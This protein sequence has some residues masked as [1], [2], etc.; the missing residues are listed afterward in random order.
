MVTNIKMTLL[1][2]PFRFVLNLA[3]LQTVT[4]GLMT[5]VWLPA[6]PIVET[7]PTLFQKIPPNEEAWSAIHGNILDDYFFKNYILQNP[8]HLPQS[9]E[10]PL[11]YSLQGAPWLTETKQSA[12]LIPDLDIP[13][14]DGLIYPN[15]AFAGVQ[16]GIPSELSIQA[17]ITKDSGNFAG[18][19]ETAIAKT[20]SAGGGVIQIEAGSFALKR[21]VV[22]TSNRV[23]IRGRGMGENGTVFRLDYGFKGK[24]IL[25]LGLVPDKANIAAV[26]PH[27]EIG[28]QAAVQRGGGWEETPPP[29]GEISIE[30]DGKSVGKADGEV[31][32][33]DWFVA[34]TGAL[35]CK[36]SGQELL[37]RGFGAGKHT[38]TA[39]VK[40]N[41][42][43]SSRTTCEF[44]LDPALMTS[45]P[46]P[47][48]MIEF[49]GEGIVGAVPIPSP[50]PR[51]TRVLS[52]VESLRLNP[53]DFIRLNVTCSPAWLARH[54]VTNNQNFSERHGIFQIKEIQSDGSV[55]LN[56]PLRFTVEE[57]EMVKI[58]KL[59][60]LQGCGIENIMMESPVP[61]VLRD[62]HIRYAA[63][64][65]AKDLRLKKPGS[66]GLWG[67]D[68]KW[69]EVRNL[70]VEDGWFKGGGMAYIGWEESFDCLLDGVKGRA[71]RHAPNIQYS[72][73]GCV[74]RNGDFEDSDGQF[75][76]GWPHENL[77]ENCT[78]RSRRGNGSYGFGFVFPVGRQPGPRNVLYNNDIAS[79]TSPGLFLGG[80]CESSLFLYNRIYTKKGPALYLQFGAFDHV[81][82]GNYFISEQPKPGLIYITTPDCTGNEFINN[83]WMG[84]P[85]SGDIKSIPLFAGAL[86]PEVICGNVFSENTGP[87]RPLPKITSLY[88]WEVN[89]LRTKGN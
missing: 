18:D 41:D 44:I 47:R 34:A 25:W 10:N 1:P 28:A 5:G 87:A 54:K 13:G 89:A 24:A 49:R 26:G 38:A 43:T 52:G 88:E 4:V 48:G 83:K 30:I 7:E 19:L 79:E 56:Q 33:R 21:P 32:K 60:L 65:W 2:K 16:G 67:R 20:V 42:G 58:E 74:I 46:V 40:W 22:V 39:T 23:V 6:A 75:H 15:F 81:F 11:G 14:P 57:G 66:G 68:N 61:S 62:V 27:C 8:Q 69:I 17:T 50:L 63:N 51:G 55:A 71:L 85:D 45:R 82:L 31:L 70:E 72:S 29:Y 36:L 37:D 12:K 3:I 78:I 53:G 77:I 76:S 59:N 35:T 9:P 73:S 84:F 80:P 64:C 86:L